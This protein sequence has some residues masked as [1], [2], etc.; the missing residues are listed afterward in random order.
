MN[1]KLKPLFLNLY[2]MVLADDKVDPQ[3]I[4]TLYEIGSRDYG[5]TLADFAPYTIGEHVAYNP[6]SLEDKLHFLYYLGE[7]AWADGIIDEREKS[8]LKKYASEC[9]FREE[10]IDA[11][12]D[13]ILDATNPQHKKP[14]E[15][16][17]KEM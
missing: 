13:Y 7:I 1:E 14:F 11:I 17:L 3:E 6:T 15:N 12:A 5:L 8:L 16:V 10:N 2:A 9:D 4:A